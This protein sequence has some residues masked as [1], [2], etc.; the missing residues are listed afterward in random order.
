M[1]TFTLVLGGLVLL[2]MTLAEQN[3]RR[4]PLS[5]A[6]LYLLL[7]WLAGLWLRPWQPSLPLNPPPALVVGVEW[8]I[9]IS[10]FGV[11]LRLP[12]AWRRQPWRLALWLASAGM[13]ITI[14][15]SS[16]AAHW[17]LGLGWAPALALGAMLAPT[18]PVLASEVQMRSARDSDAVRMSITAEGGLNDGTALPMVMLAL[19]ALGEHPVG[20]WAAGWL[21]WDLLWPVGGGAL[22]GV[23]IGRALGWVMRRLLQQG[24]PLNWDELLFVGCV[25]LT[26]GLARLTHT[27]SFIAVFACAL[28][29]LTRPSPEAAHPAQDSLTAS[30]NERLCRFGDRCERLAEVSL[31]LVVGAALS[32]ITWKA[33][34]VGFAVLM[35]LVIRPLSVMAVLHHRGL[36][37]SQRRLIAWFGIRGIGTLFY[38]LFVLTHDLP[39][40]LARTLID[41]SMICIALSIFLHGISATPLMNWY[42]ARRA[43]HA[44]PRTRP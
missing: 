21:W 3:V 34:M 1:L 40:D 30:L 19:A 33:E 2:G 36:P 5:P 32:T 31:V 35:V 7:G 28:V 26:Y 13:L 11:G 25:G 9:L 37:S 8:A 38:L 10:L 24:H 15:L 14:A 27:S 6:L 18:D 44:L 43:R 4:W 17:L 41:A 16:A 12:L 39:G 23:L 22:V 42:Q 20:P 29:L